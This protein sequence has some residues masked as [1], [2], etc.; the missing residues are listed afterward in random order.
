LEETRKIIKEPV[1]DY[2]RRIDGAAKAFSEKLETEKIR[3]GRMVGDF[4]TVQETNARAAAALQIAELSK[5]DQQR[6]EALATAATHEEI[7][8]INERANQEAQTLAP[9]FTP[10]KAEGQVNRPDWEVEVFN[11]DELNKAYPACVKKEP[12]LKEI[13]TLLGMGVALPGV[14]AKKIIKAGVR[15]QREPLAIKA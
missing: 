5:I 11:I 7:D 14:N 12:K 8:A 2:C 13:K 3:I 6:Q 15:L 9:V 1:L 10:V 4:Q